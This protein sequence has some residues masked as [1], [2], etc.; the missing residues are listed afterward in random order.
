MIKKMYITTVLKKEIFQHKL[1]WTF[2]A[3]FILIFAINFSC[4][5]Q[6]GQI[7]DRFSYAQTRVDDLQLSIYITS[8]AIRDLLADENGRREALSIFR[9]NGITKSLY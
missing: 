4:T 3:I 7:E 5:Q 8:H 1:F 6:K 9:C 2:N